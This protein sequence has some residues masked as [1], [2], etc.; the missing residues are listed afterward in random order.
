MTHLSYPTGD[1]AQDSSDP[2]D[3][4]LYFGRNEG[5]KRR[6]GA[7]GASV[8]RFRWGRGPPAMVRASSLLH[9]HKRELSPPHQPL[10]VSVLEYLPAK[11]NPRRPCPLQSRDSGRYKLTLPR[12]MSDGELKVTMHALLGY[13]RVVGEAIAG[14]ENVPSQHRTPELVLGVIGSIVED[15]DWQ[16]VP[17]W[18]D[19]DGRSLRQL[20]ALLLR[21]AEE[22]NS[23]G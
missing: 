6:S 4:G 14:I 20:H 2:M 17:G 23:E 15:D 9:C 1:T 19:E 3:T 18:T 13:M 21:M 7:Q 10:P 8:M 12:S 22:A 11:V 16:R 5:S